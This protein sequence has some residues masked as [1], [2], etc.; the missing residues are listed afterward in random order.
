MC[1]SFGG[2]FGLASP[3]LRP[4][5]VRSHRIE[6]RLGAGGHMMYSGSGS[7]GDHSRHAHDRL[8]R[9]VSSPSPDMDPVVLRGDVARGPAHSAHLDCSAQMGRY[10]PRLETAATLV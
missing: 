7:G 2:L 3:V 4:S 5:P 8:I 6:A 9:Y 10:T 1:S